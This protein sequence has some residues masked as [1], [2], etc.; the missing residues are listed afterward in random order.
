MWNKQNNDNVKSSNEER[1]IKGS[2]RGGRNN[3]YEHYKNRL[4]NNLRDPQ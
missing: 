2:P 3:A 4:E 1:F